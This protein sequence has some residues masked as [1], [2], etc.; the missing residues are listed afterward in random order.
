MRGWVDDDYDVA[1][2]CYQRHILNQR[3]DG[4]EHQLIGG[5]GWG[6]P[7]RGWGGKEWQDAQGARGRDKHPDNFH[8]GLLSSLPTE[9]LLFPKL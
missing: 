2:N 7:S 1:P 4:E 6:D 8:R 9:T 3:F 5:G